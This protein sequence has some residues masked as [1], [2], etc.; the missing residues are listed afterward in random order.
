MLFSK[1]QLLTVFLEPDNIKLVVS[2]VS[3]GKATR[4]YAGQISFP[5]TVLRDAFIA[6]SS[7]FSS[8]VKM[9]LGQKPQLAQIKGVQLIIPPEKTFIRTMDPNEDVESFLRSLPYF[10]EELVLQSYPGKDKSGQIVHLAFEKKLV[11]ELQQ[12]FLDAGKKINLVTS[13]AYL[14]SAKTNLQEDYFLIL[15]L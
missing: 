2:Q 9:A 4:T 10:K 11:E 14:L 6:D 1:Q 5:S 15:G 8:Q 3:S 12:P 7:K 13:G